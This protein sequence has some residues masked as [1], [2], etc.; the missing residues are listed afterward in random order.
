MPKDFAVIMGVAKPKGVPEG[1]PPFMK[2]SASPD[3]AEQAKPKSN[4]NGFMQKHE[5]E[6]TPEVEQSEHTGSLLSQIQAEGK[7]LGLDSEAATYFAQFAFKA[8]LKALGGEEN[9]EGEG[10]GGEV[11]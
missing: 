5:A 8:A 7:S 10:Y 3:S 2:N 9:E 11:A 6:E 1:P 4:V